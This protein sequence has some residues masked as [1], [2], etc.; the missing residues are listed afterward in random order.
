MDRLIDIS[1]DYEQMNLNF[2]LT[3]V[4]D[5]SLHEAFSLV[6]HKLIESLPYLEDLL[7]VFCAVCHTFHIKPGLIIQT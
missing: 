5:H 6:L 2:H 7:N 4:H 1:A 3:S